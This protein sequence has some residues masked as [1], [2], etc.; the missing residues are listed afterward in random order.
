MVKTFL[1]NEDI[2][3]L[4]DQVLSEIPGDKVFYSTL[5]SAVADINNGVTDNALGGIDSAKVAV[6]KADNGM[7]TVTLLDNITESVL[8]E[9]NKDINLVLNGYTLHFD[10]PE[11]RLGFTAGTN[12][13]I[14][15][16]VEGSAITKTCDAT[17]AVYM[18]NLNGDSMCIDGGTY[19]LTG[20]VKTTAMVTH[21]AGLLEINKASLYLESSSSVAGSK[22]YCLQVR[23]KMHIKDTIVS[24]RGTATAYAIYQAAGADVIVESSNVKAITLPDESVT[25]GMAICAYVAAGS[26]LSTI[27]STMLSDGPGDDAGETMTTGI[28]NYG[29]LFC[30]NTNVTGTQCGVNNAGALYV[31]G[32]TFTGYSHGGFYLSDCTTEGLEGAAYIND[33]TIRCGNYTGE[34]TDIFAGDTV[35]ILGGM[36]IGSGSNITAYLDGCSINDDN[37]GE[38]GLIVRASGGE[39]NNHLN[40]SNSTIGGYCRVDSDA[41]ELNLGHGVTLLKGAAHPDATYASYI[42]YTNEVYR[43]RHPDEQLNGNDYGALVK[44][45]KAEP[46]MELLHSATIPE[47]GLAYIDLTNLK[48]DAVTTVINSPATTT[49]GKAQ[50]KLWYNNTVL[51]DNG[52]LAASDTQNRAYSQKQE[53]W[54]QHGAWRF[55]FAYQVTG[56]GIADYTNTQGRMLL[57]SDWPYIDRVLIYFTNMP[58]GAKIY[59][60]GVKRNEN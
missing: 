24:V 39:T 46:K 25:N 6:G 20:N 48:L 44:T 56:W 50:L 15:G 4:V 19:N 16:E 42:T 8:I 28:S 11:A 38:F 43:K 22:A 37:A 3:D 26:K 47:E 13:A 27:D 53:L 7:T 9:V 23:A 34:F 59:I 29:T 54:K 35:E 21:G 31:S 60:Y 41:V 51:I 36:Y 57:E 18:I 49:Q 30:K 40:I 10:A 2:P 33:A 55:K 17:S 45:V 14:T 58:V 32:G 52:Q 1:T 12:C 5:S